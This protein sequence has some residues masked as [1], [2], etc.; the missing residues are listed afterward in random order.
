MIRY[1][2]CCISIALQARKLRFQTMTWKSFSSFPR[3]KAIEILSQ[4]VENNLLVVE[5]VIQ[6]CAE[7]NWTY[8]VSSDIIPLLTYKKAELTWDQFPNRDRLDAI[9]KRCDILAA[10]HK[11]RLSCH[12]D[13]FNVL[14][15]ENL[16]AVQQTIVELNHHGWF[17]TKLG[18][19]FDHSSPINIHINCS[20]GIPERIADRFIE[21]FEKLEKDARCRL[22]IENEDK[23]I[24]N[25]PTMIKAFDRLGI[26]FTFDYLHHKCNN[27]GIP[28]SE[29]FEV[30][31]N[32]WK[33]QSP[34]FHYSESLPDQKN[35]RKHADIPTSLPNPYGKSVDIDFEF[36]QKDMALLVASNLLK[37]LK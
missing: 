26:P 27:G 15:S 2:L 13:Q 24:W 30:C 34:L 8:R 35:P 1:G 16:Q 29:A 28:E 11:V 9:F 36:K 31:Y 6:L 3:E 14:A 10:K 17:M 18:A 23:G 20:N 22:V 25:V 33:V 21:N 12:P 32:T 37:G 4:R 19:S 5:S 7:N